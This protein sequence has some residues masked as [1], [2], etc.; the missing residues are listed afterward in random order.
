MEIGNV[1]NV[2]E[3]KPT[4]SVN[5]KNSN[6]IYFL[7][8]KNPTTKCMFVF[9][10][11]GTFAHGT[12]E[13]LSKIVE[14]TRQRVA[15][16]VYATGRNKKEVEKLQQKLAEQGITLP[17]PDYLVC[18]NGQFLYENIE[19]VLVKNTQYEAQLKAKTNFDSKKVL[20]AMTG[21]A[22]S[23][24]YKLSPSEF[25]RLERLDKYPQIRESDPLFY[26]SKISHYEWN[27]SEFMSEYFVA[28]SVP[29]GKFKADIQAEVAKA[30]IKTKFIEN[31]YPK[32]IMDACSESILLQSHPLRRHDDGSMTALFLCPA[33]KA[34][35]VKYLR[36]Q[37]DISYNEI[38]MAG[39]DDNDVSMAQ[40]SKKGAYF[41]CLNN[42]S[43]K[44]KRISN[45]LK[46]FVSTL[47][48]TLFIV[49]NDG[50]K[51]ILEGMSE[52]IG[53]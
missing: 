48:I 20:D 2:C 8:L 25:Q 41:L 42:A 13:E 49:K 22:H 9:D 4:L 5:K 19:G 45:S 38:L 16:L 23:D 34:D 14:I 29:L 27:A 6:P 37:L 46:K 30:G 17:T 24:R 12:K 15:N 21:L 1:N 36:K 10:L 26:T 32:P 18:N 51:G 40:L 35:G 11:D 31:H 28:S 3:S 50:A 53:Q 47:F 33:D 7:G 43:A 52:V 44:L 39:N